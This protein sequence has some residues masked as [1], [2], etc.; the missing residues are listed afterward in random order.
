[1]YIETINNSM[2]LKISI[3]NCKIIYIHYT[4]IY[5]FNEMESCH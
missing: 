3:P 5:I 1:M 2:R 4:Y